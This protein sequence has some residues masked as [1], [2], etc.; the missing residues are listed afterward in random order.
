M[1]TLPSNPQKRKQTVAQV[2]GVLGNMRE[3]RGAE[4]VAPS[5]SLCECGV[6]VCMRASMCV[7]VCIRVTD[8]Q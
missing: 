2:A 5:L 3:F 8:M 1:E 4:S 6:C 7:C